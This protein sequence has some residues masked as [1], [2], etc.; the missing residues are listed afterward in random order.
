MAESDYDFSKLSVLVVEDDAGG[1]TLVS[2]F[3]RRLGVKII[4]INTTG[5]GVVDI[6]R[7]MRPV[8]NLIC[9][10]LNLNNPQVNGY[11]LARQIRADPKLKDCIVVAVTAQFPVD[12]A[13]CKAAGFNGYILKPISRVRFIPQL[14]RLLNG[15]QV[16]ETE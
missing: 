2:L 14:R 13:A 5:E 6:A 9:L 16:W 8:P 1:A 3:L 7:A 10:D 11:D 15:E 12:V 4:Q